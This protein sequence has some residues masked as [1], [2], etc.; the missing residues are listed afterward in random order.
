MVLLIPVFLG[1]ISLPGNIHLVRGIEQTIDLKVPFD[2]YF[3]SSEGKISINGRKA[4]EEFFRVDSFHPLALKANQA[5]RSGLQ[6]RLFGIIPLKNI[7]V[8]VLPRISVI[9]SGEA[10][11]VFLQPEGVLVVEESFVET[12]FG[13]KLTP[14]KDAGIRAGDTILAINGIKITNEGEAATIINNLGRKGQVLEIKVKDRQ[15]NVSIKKVRPVRSKSGYYMIGVYIDDGI[16]GVGTLTFYHPETKK[17]G[18]LGHMITREPDN[19]YSSIKGKIVKAEITGVNAGKEGLPG[20]KMGVFYKKRNSLGDIRK[21]TEFGIYGQLNSR[22][23]NPYFREPIPVATSFQVREG[24]AKIYTVIDGGKI[25]EFDIVIERVYHQIK[26]APKGLVVRITDKRLLNL[27]GGIVQ[28]MSGSPIVQDGKFV[29]AVTHV[30]VNDPT[31]GY[32]VL[33]EWMVKEAGLYQEYI[34]PDSP[35]KTK[36]EPRE[37]LPEAG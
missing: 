2:L 17:Y 1:F 16:A 9:P 33:G 25:A 29:G 18:A 5:G 31:R 24:P 3:K 19:G 27:T 26:P 35:K 36:H 4:N 6:A 22:P 28:G 8:D 37:Q 15:G 32:G 34:V 7:V 30:F 11:G 14:A 12:S 10:I 13:E 21:N 20:E 23:E